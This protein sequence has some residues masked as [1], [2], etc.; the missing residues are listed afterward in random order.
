MW[1]KIRPLHGKSTVWDTFKIYKDRPWYAN[2]AI[3]DKCDK[4]I[5]RGKDL[6]RAGY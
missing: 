2:M 3:C 5:N 1:E 6:V 4:I